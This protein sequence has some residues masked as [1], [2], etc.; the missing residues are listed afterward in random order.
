MRLGL[1]ILAA[2]F[3]HQR[4]GNLDQIADDLLHVAADIADFG[5]L[6]RFH[7]DERCTS[8]PPGETAGNLRLADAGRSDHQYVL[9]H[10]LFA[11]LAFEL[12]AAPAIAQRNG[13]G[14]LGVVLADNEAVEFRD[15]FTGRS[16]S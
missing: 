2:L 13:D 4:D 16:Y 5:E 7:L 11:H 14:A 3:T 9:R 1:H 8:E 15:D 12:L 10:D 6:G